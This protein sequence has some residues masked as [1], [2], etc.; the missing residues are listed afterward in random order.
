MKAWTGSVAKWVFISEAAMRDTDTVMD[1]ARYECDK[2]V[3]EQF[4]PGYVCE[5]EYLDCETE[6]YKAGLREPHHHRGMFKFTRVYRP[7]GPEDMSK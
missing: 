4:G 1:Y 2:S 6:W 7:V 3:A 5:S